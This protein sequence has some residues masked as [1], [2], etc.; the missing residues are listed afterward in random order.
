MWRKARRPVANSLCYGADTNRNWD[1]RWMG[2]IDMYITAQI[3]ISAETVAENLATLIKYVFSMYD[4]Q[5]YSCQLKTNDR[6]SFF[7][8]VQNLAIVLYFSEAEAGVS[9]Q[10]FSDPFAGEF[11]F[12]E[13]ETRSLAEYLKSI[14]DKLVA[15]LDFHSF[16]QLLMFPY[17][18]SA[19]HV[20]NYDELVRYV[21][22]ETQK[23]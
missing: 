6:V 5:T 9:N 22:G 8:N 23:F 1:F 19:E 21:Q 3:Q 20:S 12:S 15:Y 14:S 18:H 7:D 4:T 16:S 11:P 17:G 10:P 13:R 2:K